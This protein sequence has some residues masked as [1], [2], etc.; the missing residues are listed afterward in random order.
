MDNPRSPYASILW[1]YHAKAQYFACACL[2]KNG[3][4]NVDRTPGG[5]LYLHE[6]NNLQYASSAAFLLAVYSDYLSTSNSKMACP[7]EAQ[8]QPRD[9]LDFAK[10]QADYILGKNPRSMSYLVGYGTS[11]PIHVHHRGASIPSVSMLQ[12]TVGCVQGYDAWYNRPQRN[13]NVIHGALVGG[14][15]KD[16]GFRDDRSSYKQTEPTL[17]G[18]APLIGLFSKLQSSYATPRK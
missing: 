1:Q 10:S 11:Y 13:P 4:H 7:D 15:D 16:D 14:P 9:L 3:G 12:S 2:Q 18:S 5:L 17:S 6:W 8:L